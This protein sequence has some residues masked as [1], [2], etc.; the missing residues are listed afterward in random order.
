MHKIREASNNYNRYL[1]LLKSKW[2]SALQIISSLEQL[3]TITEPQNFSIFANG[4]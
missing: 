2:Q 1:P 3:S 4:V